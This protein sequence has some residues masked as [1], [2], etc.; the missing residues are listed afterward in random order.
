[1]KVEPREA[2]Q[3]PM[4]SPEIVAATAGPLA[5]IR[6]EVRRRLRGGRLTDAAR[7]VDEVI[8]LGEMGMAMS[9]VDA[10]RDAR[11]ELAAR[12]TTRGVGGARG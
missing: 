3:L 9:E 12:R 1:M 10:L 5:T 8:L 2:D 7:L 4:P 6:G 11:R